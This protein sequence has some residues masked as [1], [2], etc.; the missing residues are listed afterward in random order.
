MRTYAQFGKRAVQPICHSDETWEQCFWRTCVERAPEWI[1]ERA[2][3][4]EAQ[5]VGAHLVH[6]SA[7]F[8]MISKCYE[9]G[10]VGSWKVL[11][12][13]MYQGDPFSQRVSLP[14]VD[15]EFFRPGMGRWNGPPS[16]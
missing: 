5:V 8:P 7:P 15:P 13:A 2:R 6:S 12:K 14:Y 10:T 9:C 11:T 4:V 1:A 16:F 3:K